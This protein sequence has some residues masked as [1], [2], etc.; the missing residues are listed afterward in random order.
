VETLAREL[1]GH[2]GIVGA[3]ILLGQ[4]GLLCLGIALQPESAVAE[5]CARV[6]SV[7]C[8]NGVRVDGIRYEA[9]ASP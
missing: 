3:E 4:P 5:V 7:A 2:P 1:L 8:L 9:E 6:L